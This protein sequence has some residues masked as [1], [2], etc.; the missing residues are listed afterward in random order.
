VDFGLIGVQVDNGLANG[1]HP[2]GKPG[3]Q[4]RR[5][6][7]GADDYS[8]CCEAFAT[9]LEQHSGNSRFFFNHSL[10]GT[11]PNIHINLPSEREKVGYN[12]ITFD[13]TCSWT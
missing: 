12:K 9:L 8:V 2:V 6:C 11:D 10:G 3:E 1:P 4:G 7:S 13:P 5:P